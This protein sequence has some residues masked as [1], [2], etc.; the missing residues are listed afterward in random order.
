[1]IKLVITK[2]SDESFYV[3]MSIVRELNILVGLWIGI[4]DNKI[5]NSEDLIFICNGL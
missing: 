5:Y 2:Y 3:K 1:M 4:D